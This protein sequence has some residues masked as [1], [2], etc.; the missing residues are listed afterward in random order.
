[1]GRGTQVSIPSIFPTTTIL[2]F[3]DKI[4]ADILTLGKNKT[5]EVSLKYD[6]YQMQ[7]PGSKKGLM[8]KIT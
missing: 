7:L 2:F 5:N 3:K 6:E 1:M 4:L 8:Q